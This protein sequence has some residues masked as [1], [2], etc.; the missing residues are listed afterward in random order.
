M[1]APGRRGR[2]V[3]MFEMFE[4]VIDARPL[5]PARQR[6]AGPAAI[7]LHAIVVGAL[8]AGSAWKV[9]SIGEPMVPVVFAAPP[10]APPPPR[11]NPEGS[12]RPRPAA[13]P[14]SVESKPAVFSIP[15]SIP[16]STP[17]AALPALP[18]IALGAPGSDP[19]PRGD[20]QG[21]DDGT[22]DVSM[23]RS[24]AGDQPISAAAPNVTPPRLLTQAQPEYPEAARRGRQQGIVILQAIIGTGGEVENVQVLSSAS[25]LFDDPAVR[26]LR[27]WRYAPA[28]L[29][30][31][32]VRVYLTV[33]MRFML[34]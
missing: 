23:P 22:G 16:A 32:A 9:G 20:P 25:P 6:L 29:D 13:A 24:G 27:Q 15:A 17:S 2:E 28:T 31:R 12:E 26:A 34:H 33:T 5:H 7:A 18:T 11:G 21:V 8:V 14:K 4:S 19:G 3:A 1:P 10:L 30:R